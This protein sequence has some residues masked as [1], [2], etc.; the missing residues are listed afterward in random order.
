MLLSKVQ[1]LYEQEPFV[2]SLDK[3]VFFG[4]PFSERQTQ[5]NAQ[6]KTYVDYYTKLIKDSV[7]QAA[8]MGPNFRPI[9]DY[10]TLPPEPIIHNCDFNETAH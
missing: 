9:N 7:K 1:A 2:L 6:L 3:S 4:V 10:F 5:S 8:D